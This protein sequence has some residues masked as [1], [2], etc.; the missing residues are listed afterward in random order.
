MAVPAPTDE[1]LPERP[2]RLSLDDPLAPRRPWSFWREALPGGFHFWG[3]Q[4]IAGWLLFQVLT[5]AV[6]AL[7]L[8]AH[9]GFGLGH[10]GGS[11]LT[12]HWGEM[13]SA[14]AVWELL[15]NGGL[16]NDILGTATP[17]IAA[18]GLGWLLWSGWRLQAEAAG[19]PGRAGPWL[20]GFLDALLIGTLPLALAAAPL[21]WGL[22]RLAELGFATLGWLNL[23]GGTVLRAAVVSALLLQW[24]LCRLNRAASPSGGW[25]LGS[26]EAYGRHL[27]ASFLALWRHP[28]HWGTLL[29]AGAALRLGL[30]GLV[31]WLGWRMGGGS[32]GRV[33]LF[34]L[35]QAL[36]TA[37]GAWL[38][39]W[40]LRLTGLHWAQDRKVALARTEFETR[41]GNS[42]AAA[43]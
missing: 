4:F 3:R 17:V 34:L 31:L 14:R 7:H 43:T 30:S 35:L 9:A 18:F 28:I 42:H 19:V 32:T 2:E 10:P 24:W 11:G 8:K 29:V 37:A 23:A 12:N 26:W 27:A 36:A 38:I 16:K 40:F 21:L 1:N 13:L 20:M 25:R 41:F 39:G 33:W 15:E 22:G 5:S 6:W